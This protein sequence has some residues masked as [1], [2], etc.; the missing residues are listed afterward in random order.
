M[1]LFRGKFNAAIWQLPGAD[2]IRRNVFRNEYVVNI[3]SVGDGENSFK[4]LAAY[5]QRGFIG[6]DRIV[7]YNGV[8]SG[9]AME[10][11]MKIVIE[12]FPQ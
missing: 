9:I 7:K 4:Y 10:K 12:H 11:Q 1:R 5:T 2:R 3:K 8:K 6:N